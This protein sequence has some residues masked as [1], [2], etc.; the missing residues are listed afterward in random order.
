MS[1]TLSQVARSG[2]LPAVLAIVAMMMMMMLSFMSGI[3]MASPGPAMRAPVEE[4]P[5]LRKTL[6]FEV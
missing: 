1:I 2:L 6:R 5:V 4:N 3:R